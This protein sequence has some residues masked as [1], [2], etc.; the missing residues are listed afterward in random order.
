MRWF[1][2]GKADEAVLQRQEASRESLIRGGLPLN[3]LDRL[4]EQAARQGTPSHLFT[5][6]L[7]VSE[8]HLVERAGYEAL[9]QVMGSSVYHVGWQSLPFWSGGSG[10]LEVL[11]QAFYNARHLALNRLQQEAAVLGATGV[12]GVRLERKSYEWG[13]GLLE[14]AAIGTAIREESAPPNPTGDRTLPFLS[15][16]SGD[17]FWKLRQSGYR[18]VG[19]GVGN[20]TYYQ[21]PTWNSQNVTSGGFFSGSWRNQELPDYTQALYQARELAMG[22]LEAEGL[23]LKA[24]GIVGVAMEVDAQPRPVGSEDNRRI[25]MIYHFTAIGTAIYHAEPRRNP[26]PLKIVSL[27]PK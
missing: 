25:D 3:A 19:V 10:E 26:S 1:G 15:D 13:A 21:V 14:F 18:P 6:D 5:G 9:G 4:R 16:L 23:R 11:T 17:E 2:R 22:R 8:L 12:V 24:D 7:S 27:K 20:C